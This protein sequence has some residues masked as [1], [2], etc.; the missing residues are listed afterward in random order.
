MDATPNLDTFLN[1]QFSLQIA[2]RSPITRDDGDST[3]LMKVWTESKSYLLKEVPTRAVRPELDRIFKD[4]WS[5]FLRGVDLVLPIAGPDGKFLQQHDGKSYVLLEWEDLK[6]FS[7]TKIDHKEML[8][9]F[10]HFHEAVWEFRWPWRPGKTLA[11]WYI[12]GVDKLTEKF[13]PHEP[14]LAR[15]R[16]FAQDRLP[17]LEFTVGNIH[18]DVHEH[19]VAF[20][21]EGWLKILDFD[22]VQRGEVFWDLVRVTAMYGAVNL[23]Q[24]WAMIDPERI[25]EL[26]RHAQPVSKGITAQDVRFFLARVWLGPLQDPA[27]PFE[28]SAPKFL[29]SIDEFL[30]V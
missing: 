25:E 24:G 19:N 8:E 5:V 11:T 28:E 10:S 23:A 2:G 12:R 16:E 7:Q 3:L 6:P 22:E 29:R 9:T 27:Y 15:L 30:S 21:K 18:T 17:N 14:C 4:L 20:A 1:E 26:V 13:G